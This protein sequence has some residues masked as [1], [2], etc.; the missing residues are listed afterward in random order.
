MSE[1]C[2]VCEA[3]RHGDADTVVL[4]DG[5]WSAGIA[6]D[7]PGWL[8]L[9]TAR[10]GEWAWDLTDLEAST[11]GPAVARLSAALRA[12]TGAETVYLIALGENSRHFHMLLMA[13]G[14]DTPPES[15]GPAL[16]GRVAELADPAEARR[17]AAVVREQLAGGAVT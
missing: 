15:R 17:I 7:V 2:H 1:T 12:A 10:H 8:R 13:R 16:L 6:G 3:A 4:D 11:L 9:Q 14:A 5:T